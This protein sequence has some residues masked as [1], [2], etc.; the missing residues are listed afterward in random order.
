M[1]RF[2]PLLL[3]L[4]CKT[5]EEPSPHDTKPVLADGSCADGSAPT[6]TVPSFCGKVPKNLIF[7][8]IDTLRKDHLGWYS[9][10]VKI[11]PFLDAIAATGVTLDNNV[12]CSNWTFASTSCT[13][14]GRTH[15]DNGFMPRLVGPQPFP[16][17]TRFLSGYLDDA[18]YYSQLVSGN[19]WLGNKHANAQGF[20]KFSTPGG[21]RTTKVYEKSMELFD[22]SEQGGLID[23]H[24]FIHMHLLEPHAAYNPPETFLTDLDDLEPVEWDLSNM[25]DMY[26]VTSQWPILTESEQALLEQHLRVRYQGEI[27]Y[28]DDQLVDVWKGLIENGLL[29][30]TLVVFWSD[31]GEAFWEHDKQTHAYSLFGV[32][33][34]AM[35]YFWSRNIVPER[36]TGPTQSIDIVP[37]VLGLF[38][39]PVPDE[40][41]GIPL[42]EAPEDRVRY[43]MASARMG[44]LTSVIDDGWKLTMRWQGGMTLS[45]PGE[46]PNEAE[47]FYHPDDPKTLELWDLLRPRVE[48]AEPLVPET[49][50]IWPIGLP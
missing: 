18:G 47:D 25:D 48:A 7:I 32:E 36:W 13:L 17:G 12:Q 16:D 42:G 40:V 27:A 33:N 49:N 45:H 19:S 2:A 14:L 4:C 10:T 8:S 41:T 21:G 1:T 38:D 44:Q 34:D 37:T 28:M 3:L 9:D 29:Y 15:I 24:W 23:K 11:T 35:V 30:D 50:I 5:I 43:T 31:H 6:D 20:T 46:D 39:L 22:A 26:D